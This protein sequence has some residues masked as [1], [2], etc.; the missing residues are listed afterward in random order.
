MLIVWLTE[1]GAPDRWGDLPEVLCGEQ[2]DPGG[3]GPAEGGPAESGGE[4]RNAG[5]HQT[6]GTGSKR[7]L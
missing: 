2:G 6:A 7:A 1:R 5:L 4:P 3:E